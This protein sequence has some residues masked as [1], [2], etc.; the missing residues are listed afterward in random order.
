MIEMIAHRGFWK[1]KHEQNTMV[2][3]T[4][5][6]EKKY[7]IETDIRD[8]NGKVIISHDPYVGQTPIYFEDVLKNYKS[9]NSHV[10]LALNVKTDGISDKVKELLHRFQIKNY[11]VF[12]ASVPELLRYRNNELVYFS[13]HSEYEESPNLYDRAAGIW[14]DQFKEMWFQESTISEHL[15]AGK[16]VCVVS[17]ELHKRE[18]KKCWDFLRL[19]KDNSKVSLCTDF[20]DQAKEAIYG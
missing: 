12:D 14:L 8:F 16:K 9:Y 17:S 5:C 7:G 13:R 19:F 20:P 10:T 15:K 1:E 6:F 3:F 2:S 11:F 18:H 4:Q